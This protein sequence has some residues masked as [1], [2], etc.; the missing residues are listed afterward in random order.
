MVAALRKASGVA[1]I[2]LIIHAS[3]YLALPSSLPDL[4]DKRFG[5]KEQRRNGRGILKRRA[6]NLRRIDDARLRMRFSPDQKR[7]IRRT[8]RET[9]VDRRPRDVYGADRAK[10]GARARGE[11]APA[12]RRRMTPSSQPRSDSSPASVEESTAAE[13]QHHEDDDE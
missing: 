8:G 13:Q 6:H 2:F 5:G 3:K 9:I 12:V 11:G 1:D 10:I 7:C 4:A